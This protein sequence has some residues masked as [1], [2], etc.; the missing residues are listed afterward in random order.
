MLSA[1]LRLKK[2]KDFETIFIQKK[3]IFTRFFCLYYAKELSCAGKF[4]F[5]VSTKV[6][7]R[8]VVRNRLRRQ[9]RYWTKQQLNHFSTRYSYIVSAK[10]GASDLPYLDLSR[11]LTG[12]F[13]KAKLWI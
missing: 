6:D 9:M 2:K 7:K 1:A 8:A 11:A 10:P 13:K 3:A 5:L 12:L 4:A